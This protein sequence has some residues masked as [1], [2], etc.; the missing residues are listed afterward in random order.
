MW[1]EFRNRKLEARKIVQRPPVTSEF[2]LLASALRRPA[3][4]H[5]CEQMLECLIV[6]MAFFSG[7]LTR[8]FVELRGHPGGFFRR[9][10]ER[11]E[12]LGE[13]RDFHDKIESG[14]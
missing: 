4:L 7:K 13:L 12:D 2:G 9:A 10:A 6:T 5:Q 3:L 14:K 8:A 11:D 1:T